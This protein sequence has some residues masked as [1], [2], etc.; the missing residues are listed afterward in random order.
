[1]IFLGIL[2]STISLY[3]IF[4][5]FLPRNDLDDSNQSESTNLFINIKNILTNT[6]NTISTGISSLWSLFSF[7]ELIDKSAADAADSADSADLKET[8]NNIS[9]Q[10]VNSRRMYLE[11]QSRLYNIINNQR[12][13]EE[14]Q[15]KTIENLKEILKNMGEKQERSQEFY[16]KN[17][18]FFHK[19]IEDY[20]NNKID[21]EHYEELYNN[22]KEKVF[23]NN[24]NNENENITRI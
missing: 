14:E 13:R 23:N 24:E 16:I 2:L 8:K 22:L 10:T 5:N 12:I 7:T 6:I 21:D 3:Y 9:T 1:M 20:K 18:E 19:I 4:G 17:M 11:N 15:K